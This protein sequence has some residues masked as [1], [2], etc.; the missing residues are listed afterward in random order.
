MRKVIYINNL[1]KNKFFIGLSLK[2]LKAFRVI[3]HK[4]YNEHSPNIFNNLPVN[5]ILFLK[6]QSRNHLTHQINFYPVIVNHSLSQF[7]GNI[8]R[9]STKTYQ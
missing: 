6:K 7:L 3:Y 2:L 5:P 1:R 8:P 9:N 4:L